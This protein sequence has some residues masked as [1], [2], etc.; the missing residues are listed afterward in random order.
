MQ[1]DNEGGGGGVDEE[2]NK[3]GY[4]GGLRLRERIL[5]R[6]R[7]DDDKDGEKRGMGRE[8]RG[9]IAFGISM[10]NGVC[11]S[12]TVHL[13]RNTLAMCFLIG[14]SS[15]FFLLLFLF[16]FILFCFDFFKR[17]DH[18]IYISEEKGQKKK[19]VLDFVWVMLGLEGY[20]LR[21]QFY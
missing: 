19:G 17:R 11:G 4:I 10:Q 6:E 13:A 12:F 5:V 15:I 18:L 3:V 16:Y 7:D 20:T 8:I 2:G 9:C 1:S 21:V 14:T